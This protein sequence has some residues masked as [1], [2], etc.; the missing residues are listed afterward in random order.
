M[1][2]TF[3]DNRYGNVCIWLDVFDE[4]FSTY[5]Y[6]VFCLRWT[7]GKKGI[8][9]FG[10]Y[11]PTT[12]ILYE[13]DASN[14]TRQDEESTVYTK[15]SIANTMLYQAL[16][17]FKDFSINLCTSYLYC[18]SSYIIYWSII[19]KYG[20]WQKYYRIK[21]RTMDCFYSS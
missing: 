3:H 8:S 16:L 1:R 17:L 11:C 5:F 12:G 4:Y 18:I 21:C 9:D 15:Y 2:F 20:I 13:L 10:S 14:Y 19:C 7:K 6:P